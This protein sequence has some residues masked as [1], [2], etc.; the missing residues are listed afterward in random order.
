MSRFIRAFVVLLLRMVG[1]AGM[2]PSMAVFWCFRAIAELAAE[3][4]GKR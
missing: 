3:L 1:L 4:E 2:V